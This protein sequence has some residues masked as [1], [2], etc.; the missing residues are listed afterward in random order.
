MADC[1]GST[2][3]MQ[4]MYCTAGENYSAVTAAAAYLFD[5]GLQVFRAK[6]V[7]LKG[8]G[9]AAVTRLF[10]LLARRGSEG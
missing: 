2:S 3:P 6:L 4:Y 9:E 8:G 5:W 10:E 1:V 7:F